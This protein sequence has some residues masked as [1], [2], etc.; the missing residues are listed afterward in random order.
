MSSASIPINNALAFVSNKTRS[1]IASN[2]AHFTTISENVP[3]QNGV[4]ECQW[5]TMG[6]DVRALL[7]MSRLPKSYQY[8]WLALNHAC[9]ISA[10]IPW[11]DQPSMS[12]WK[13]MTGRAPSVGWVR[14]WGCLCY[15]KL[16]NRQS[17]VHEQSARH[18]FT[19][20][21]E[22]Q[23]GY[24]CVNPETGQCTT[25]PHMRFVESCLPG[26]VRIG[27]KT[28]VVPDFAPDFNPDAPPPDDPHHLDITELGDEMVGG[29]GDDTVG[30]E[31]AQAILERRAMQRVALIS[32]TESDALSAHRP[33]HAC[34]LF[35]TAADTA[36]VPSMA[37]LA[38][39]SNPFLL[40]IGSG[41]RRPAD[42]GE[43]IEK[44]SNA[45]VINIDTRLGG[46]GHDLRLPADALAVKE[47]AALAN[48]VGIHVSVPC[49]TW[50][51]V[52]FNVE[53]EGPQPLRDCD[54]VLGIPL[55][56]G[57]LPSAAIAA[58]AITDVAC[59]AARA[60]AAH[61]GH[62]VME[63]PVPRGAGSP[64]AIPDRERHASFWSHPS[65]I[66]LVADLRLLTVIFDQCM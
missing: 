49:D 54:N 65:V 57:S 40:Y 58:N 5:R 32:F 53:A 38:A 11:R 9:H 48:C 60:C 2:G 23:P 36:A 19:G 3:R 14:V 41:T 59:D 35:S 52:K 18:I 56:D 62:V 30:G 34:A 1:L 10:L 27:G 13:A 6:R 50:S 24:V 21:S 22:D 37:G 12:G 63:S 42:F 46:Y 43:K 4:C 64:F 45:T 25:S 8:W 61:G 29:D 51:A 33:L 55:A 31:P 16:F 47:L 26:L 39:P 20:L 44:T 28:A 15:P 7:S 66:T 17:K